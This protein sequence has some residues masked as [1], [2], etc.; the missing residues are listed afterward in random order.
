MSGL[1]EIA[2]LAGSA[3]SLVLWWP[4][5]LVVWRCRR[6]PDRLRGVSVTSQV[7]LLLNAVLWGFYAVAA[8]SL[9]VGAPG[10]V[11]APLA[12]VTIVVLRR[13]ASV[14]REASGSRT[15]P[16]TPVGAGA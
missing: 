6:D 7:L 8:E 4:Q 1:T 13:S 15:G 10:L 16:V 11:N 3:V 12:V 2:G 14:R 5:A 9:W